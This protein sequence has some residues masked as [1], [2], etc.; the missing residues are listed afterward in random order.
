M[1]KVILIGRLTRDPEIR[2]SSSNM[3]IMRDSIAVDKRGRRDENN[4]DATADFINIV[5]FGQ[6][7]ENINKFFKKGSRMAL[8]GHINTGSYDDKDGKKV[9]TTD[10][11]VDSFDF[12]ESK[13]ASVDSIPTDNNSGN[14]TETGSTKSVFEEFGQ[15]IS[16]TSDDED[17]PF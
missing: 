12:I 13:G 14:N 7:A 4:G 17:L 3:A 9:Y 10:V 5:A 16:T 2:Y 1:N 11:V 8:E 15:S 6:T